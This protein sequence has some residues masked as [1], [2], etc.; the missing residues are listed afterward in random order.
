LAG[1]VRKP[2]N[3]PDARSP[4]ADGLTH[5]EVGL[6]EAVS[7]GFD[8]R[9]RLLDVGQGVGREVATL[10]GRAGVGL[11]S[12]WRGEARGTSSGSCP[13]HRKSV[14]IFQIFDFIG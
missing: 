1:V 12:I 2:D 3:D 8:R 13:S 10:V 9:A 7:L 5:E 6:R 4:S 14:V 11:A